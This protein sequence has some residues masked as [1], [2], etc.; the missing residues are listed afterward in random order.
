MSS[1]HL[2]AL[3][4]VLLIKYLNFPAPRSI[5]FPVTSGVPFL[6]CATQEM[7]RLLRQ[8]GHTTG[9]Q[10]KWAENRSSF[11]IANNADICVVAYNKEVG[12]AKVGRNV[13]CGSTAGRGVEMWMEM[14]SVSAPSAGAA[15]HHPFISALKRKTLVIIICCSVKESQLNSAVASSHLLSRY[16]L[17]LLLLFF[18]CEVDGKVN[19]SERVPQI[20]AA[21]LANLRCDPHSRTHPQISMVRLRGF[22]PLTDSHNTEGNDGCVLAHRLQINAHSFHS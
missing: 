20:T 15:L 19:Q 7:G 3:L 13:A 16:M 12:A 6:L 17:F 4:S 2:A 5:S 10:D 21:A 11:I 1:I 18:F 9:R 14:M 8:Q 22:H